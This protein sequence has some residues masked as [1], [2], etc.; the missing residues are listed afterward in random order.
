MWSQAAT[1]TDHTGG[2]VTVVRL[3]WYRGHEPTPSCMRLTFN[4][5]VDAVGGRSRRRGRHQDPVYFTLHTS[6]VKN[7]SERNAHTDGARDPARSPMVAVRY[8]PLDAMD[9]S[10]QLTPAGDRQKSG[11]PPGSSSRPEGGSRTM[12]RRIAALR[13]SALTPRSACRVC[14][15]RPPPSIPPT[16]CGSPSLTRRDRRRV[17]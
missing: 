14:P 3:G 2:T 10:N 9:L 11:L 5:D 16:G 13:A 8:D 4:P 7:L 17:R 1:N 15:A 12:M 6:S